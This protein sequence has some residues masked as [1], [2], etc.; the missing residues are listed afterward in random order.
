MVS[1]CEALFSSKMEKK[2]KK[3]TPAEETVQESVLV[4]S[5]GL[6][7]QLR[8]AAKEQI[9]SLKSTAHSIEMFNK[10]IKMRACS[11]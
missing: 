3:Q 4:P 6:T 8:I 7:F 10:Q 2:K 5:F 1:L 11:N 9:W